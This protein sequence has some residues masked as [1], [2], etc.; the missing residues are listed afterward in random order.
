M[1]AFEPTVGSPPKSGD[2]DETP[3]VLG[4]T[5]IRPAELTA[6][7]G[8][9]DRTAVVAADPD[10]GTAVACRRL[11]V[12]GWRQ[13]RRHDPDALLVYNGSG[14]IGLVAVLLSAVSGCP[15]IV[16]LNGDILRQHREKIGEHWLRRE[17]GATF[18]YVLLTVATRLT[19]AVADGFVVVSRNLKPIVERQTG[20]A[21]AKIVAVNNPLDAGT[22][23]P[24]TTTSSGTAGD[25]QMRTI[26]TV[27]NLQ[28]R[29]K[30]EGVVD[31]IDIVRPILAAAD[32]VEYV[33]AGDGLYLER[34]RQYVDRHVVDPEIR[35]RIRTPGYV[36]DVAAL[37]ED[38][39]VFAY[40]SYIDAYP[41]VVIEAQAAG[42]PVVANAAHG[43]V[44]Q[45]SH[46]ESGRL[47]DEDD[48]QQFRRDIRELLADPD[49]RQRLG[50]NA[51]AVVARRTD[52]GT[53]GRK[54]VAAVDEIVSA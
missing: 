18:G 25:E 44:D 23:R 7:M 42:L 21:P 22:Y 39:D 51:A 38:A 6:P 8:R 11:L 54:L 30:Y 14:M 34:L 5:D 26:L 31:L 3:F 2:S 33:V 15:L 48:R 10:T 28:F 12:G 16:R 32:D 29:G 19:F 1:S 49:E 52:P 40:R 37:Y 4:L 24:E 13:L 47:V 9:V 53:V 45:I 36:S 35:A 17:F 41:N 20:C 27:T 46:D 43:I 50:S